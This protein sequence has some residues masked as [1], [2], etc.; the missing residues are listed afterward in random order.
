MSSAIPSS[1]DGQWAQWSGFTTCQFQGVACG[2]GKQ[3]KSRSCSD[4]APAG[5][6]QC[7]KVDGSMRGMDETVESDCYVACPDN[8]VDGGWGAW[9]IHTNCSKECD[10]GMQTVK[11]E[12]NFPSPS[13]NGAHCQMEN[14]SMGM[15]EM[16]DVP[17]NT[18]PCEPLD[19]FESWGPW[20]PC[21]KTCGFGE[22]T[23]TRQCTGIC[24][25]TKET[26]ECSSGCRTY[27]C[28]DP[29][30]YQFYCDF[31]DNM[32]ITKFHS[33]PT[34]FV[35]GKSTPSPNTGADADATFPTGCGS[36]LYFDSSLF[37]NGVLAG[38]SMIA[39][40]GQQCIS[41]DVNM[42]ANDMNHMGNLTVYFFQQ[43]FGAGYKQEVIW[44]SSKDLTPTS[45]K[46][47]K[48]NIDLFNIDNR[49]DYRILF[50]V[51]K[52]FGTFLSD[53]SIDN[54]VVKEGLCPESVDGYWST[55]E[56]WGKCSET[57]GDG[58]QTRKRSCTFP[59][60]RNEGKTCAGNPTEVR[61][62]N[63]KACQ[64]FGTWSAWS[65]WQECSV[66]C[67]NGTTSRERVCDTQGAVCLLLD[68]SSGI[69]EA[70]KMDCNMEP[71]DRDGGWGSWGPYQ[72]CSATC[73]TATKVR[74]RI[75]DNPQ[76][77]QNGSFCKLDVPLENG[78]HVYDLVE[79]EKTACTLPVCPTHGNWNSWVEGTCSVVCGNGTKLRYRE[80]NNPAPK[81]FGL[82][83]A[84]A[85]GLN[86]TL[87]ESE[88]LTCSSCCP[89][90]G[91]WVD[92]MNTTSCSVECGKGNWTWERVCTNA[93]CD[94][95][96]V[97]CDGYAPGDRQYVNRTCE[98][99]LDEERSSCR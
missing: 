76:P 48:V 12:C 83:C 4:P 74:S 86:Q 77:R 2:W 40:T 60:P 68:G 32:C 93:S 24:S 61:S 63:D 85:T 69:K 52:P 94:G 87:Y 50:K 41:F 23:R 20:S 25:V 47:H 56:D 22:M 8:V 49:N 55:W 72:A 71:C 99:W 58:L 73:G 84:N 59:Y 29:S 89:T 31:E 78:I 26:R 42:Y 96:H 97:F 19:T 81:D 34:K 18:Q 30:E 64:A 95:T 70:Q 54:Y 15:V 10:A 1:G 46:W 9:N 17:C 90:N 35:V 6:A 82:K 43:Q 14:G 39:P 36:F 88:N 7:L 79:S 65:P 62:C 27:K 57:C 67:N 91:T 53:V 66:S 75:C 16:K 51:Q 45:K 28:P 13:I 44:E 37:E 33:E 5:G 21:T 11:R 38:P 3:N 98:N 80:C 92:V